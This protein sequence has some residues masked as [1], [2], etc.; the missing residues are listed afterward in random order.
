MPQWSKN[1]TLTGAERRRFRRIPVLQRALL[2][3]AGSRPFPGEISDFCQGG[4]FLRLVGSPLALKPGERWIGRPI[5]IRFV[6]E[7]RASHPA[8]GLAGTVVRVDGSGLGVAFNGPEASEALE[9]LRE[10]ASAVNRS[11]PPSPEMER[12][13]RDALEAILPDIMWGFFRHVQNDLLDAA[14]LEPSNS[15]EQAAYLN[16]VP[17]FG[18]HAELAERF[19]ERVMAQGGRQGGAAPDEQAP[20]EA[21]SLSLLEKEPFED[22][23]NL[24][25]EA[26]RLDALF[27]EPLRTL[28][29]RLGGGTAVMEPK[30][31]PYGPTALCRAFHEAT[32]NLSLSNSARM[33]AYKA[34]GSALRETLGLFYQQLL[35]LT[36]SLEGE[37]PSPVARASQR[38]GGA[39]RAG[40]DRREAAGGARPSGPLESDLSSTFAR[41]N[42]LRSDTVPGAKPGD[43]AGAL[44]F[45]SEVFQNRL[46][47]PQL[48]ALHFLGAV[49]SNVRADPAV[50]QGLHPFL[51]QWQM[52]LL[53]LA[54]SD[55]Q[56][57]NEPGHPA[58]KLLDALDALALAADSQG[59]IEEGLSRRLSDWSERLAQD[60][61][62][63]PEALAQ[64]V[65]GLEELGAPLVRTRNARIFRLR[66]A[67]ESQQRIEAARRQV[68]TEITL[69]LAGAL[70]PKVVPELLDAGWREWLV[71]GCLRGNEAK[72]WL[73]SLK[74]LDSLLIW[75]APGGRLPEPL[76]AYRLIEYVEEHLWAYSQDF[77][78]CRRL[79]DRLAALLIRG[80]KPE[81]IEWPE[82]SPEASAAQDGQKARILARLRS[83]QVGGWYRIAREAGAAPEP[84]NLVW[85][86]EGR[87]RY[88]FVDR[89]GIKR[90]DIDAE[91]FVRYLDE[92]RAVPFEGLQ[93]PLSERVVSDLMRSVQDGLRYQVYFDPATGLLNQ[94]GFAGRLAQRFA[95]GGRLTAQ[96]FLCI[97]EIDQFREISSLCGPEDGER[98]LREVAG[99]LKQALVG[100]DAIGRLGDHRFGA[101]FSQGDMDACRRR[102]EQTIEAIARYRFQSGK[103][104][105][106]VGAHVGLVGLASGVASSAE[107]LKRADSACLRARE[108]GVNQV[109]FYAA[110]DPS[111][112]HTEQ[113]MDWG[114]RIDSLLAEQRLCVRC[115]KIAPLADPG[116]AAHYEILLGIRGEDGRLLPPADF[117]A[118]AERWNRV[119]EVD[120]FQVEAVFSW[121]R[122]DPRRLAAVG[123]FSINLSGQ[124]VSSEKFMDFLHA[125]LVAADWPLEKITFEITET[126]AIA[127][128]G[129][130]ERFIRRIRRHGCR[131]SLDDFGCGF[132][133]YAYLKNLQVDYLK[134]DGSFV[135]DLASSAADYAMVKSMNEVGHSLGIKTIAEYVETEEILAKLHEIGVDYVQ[136]Y[137]VGKPMLLSDLWP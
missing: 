37:K 82:P 47:E 71:L 125:Q 17:V 63:D 136:G 85:I 48:N 31:S 11:S 20:Q 35:Q 58:R 112:S 57:L 104:S 55:P 18:A 132:A 42:Q 3:V 111:L 105:F 43:W 129:Q 50:P 122:R 118:A 16:A 13:C 56:L 44:A 64:V 127:E 108:K 69:R 116:A 99:I 27:E 79:L 38:P 107:A 40:R 98:L 134:I 46:R 114:G 83:C 10:V 51:K 75:L 84:L 15:L 66:E 96:E 60:G 93:L 49:L 7:H 32:A 73:D 95:V 1:P 65:K 115:Q 30:A 4:V 97:L 131:F 119:S 59:R 123:G 92:H 2:E 23:L 5:Q 86:E 113:I 72:E 21:G 6:A 74:V 33:V 45:A 121:I 117:V 25:A 126:A 100:A 135:K 77:A 8:L 52:P 14:R 94:K 89:Q 124:S 80:E 101:L 29:W 91:T 70:V 61:I 53:K 90:L 81:H 110:D 133:S 67:C 68:D 24:T 28:E 137:Y 109:Q 87:N 130:A 78:A 88:V 22:W 34:L 120:R 12:A 19:R 9:A 102:A 128:F 103:G 41:L 54:I 62:R 39:S 106:A 36:E 76:A 26:A